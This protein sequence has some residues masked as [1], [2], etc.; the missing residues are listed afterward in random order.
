MTFFPFG[1]DI[2]IT[3]RTQDGVDDQGDAIVTDTTVTV[4]GA[5]APA[6]SV[7]TT[8]AQDQVTTQAQAYL[9]AGTVVSSTSKLTIRGIDYEVTGDPEDWGP[10]PVTGWNPGILGPVS[11]KRITG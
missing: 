8:V 2:I 5:F 10:S 7:E 4:S 6:A 11:L 3:T 9:P 1:E